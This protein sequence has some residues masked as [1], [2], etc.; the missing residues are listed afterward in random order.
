MERKEWSQRYTGMVKFYK[1]K[2][3]C[4]RRMNNCL[5]ESLGNL[6]RVVSAS[7]K[8]RSQFEGVYNSTE[9]QM[10]LTE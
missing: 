10:P 2:C 7:S 8:V 4:D 1:I 9:H 5:R 6:V 3:D